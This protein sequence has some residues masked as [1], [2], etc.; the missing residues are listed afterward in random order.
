MD[1]VIPES[2]DVELIESPFRTIGGPWATMRLK[3]WRYVMRSS[4]GG[5]RIWVGLCSA[6][7]EQADI[8]LMSSVPCKTECIFV[9]D[10]LS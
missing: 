9:G 7:N 5:V 6:R 3:D 8:Q 2:L 1:I 10:L 4:Y